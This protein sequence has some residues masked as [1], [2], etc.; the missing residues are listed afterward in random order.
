VRNK[1]AAL[2]LIPGFL[3]ALAAAAQAQTEKWDK[4]IGKPAPRLYPAGWVGT[5]VSLDALRKSDA[6]ATPE[7]DSGATVARKSEISGGNTVVLAFWNADI[8][9]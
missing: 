6:N 9:C 4:D 5:P 7:T 3:L 2:A 1:T 8:P